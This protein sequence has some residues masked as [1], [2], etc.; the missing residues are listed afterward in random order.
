MS[1]KKR[2][3]VAE[4]NVKNL[5]LV[6]DCL[7]LYGIEVLVATTGASAV[8]MALEHLPDL[9]LMDYHMPLMDGR[10]ATKVLKTSPETKHIPIIAVTAAAMKG[11][12]LMLREAGSDGYL[13]KPVSIPELLKLMKRYLGELKRAEYQ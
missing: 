9:V 1:E 13:A 11:D 2:V 7:E 8:H 10:A 12:E 5:E 3:L 6:K 4:D